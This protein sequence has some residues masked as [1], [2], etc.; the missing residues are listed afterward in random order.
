MKFEDYEI[1]GKKAYNEKKYSEA[2][3]YFTKA[4][5]L[6]T[7]KNLLYWV[8]TALYKLQNYDEAIKYFRKALELDSKFKECWEMLAEA[9]CLV[10]KFREA[11]KCYEKAYE[12]SYDPELKQKINSLKYIWNS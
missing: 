7:D 1:F 6:K 2:I 11:V 12:L 4:L 8:G 10:W 9:L 5:E 3:S